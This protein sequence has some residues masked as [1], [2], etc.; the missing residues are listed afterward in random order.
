MRTVLNQILV[1]S[2]LPPARCGVATYAAEHI[3]Q[4]MGRAFVV[5]TA[6]TVSD[7]Q[8]EHVFEITGIRGCLSWLKFCRRQKGQQVC[9]HY[10]D[11]HFFPR[12]SGGWMKR[13]CC[14]LLQSIALR[15]LG[16]CSGNASVVFHELA[17]GTAM[18]VVSSKL[19]VF[20]FR[21]WK[22]L[23]FHT[24]SM[25][26]ECLR[27]YR[28]LPY[29]KCRIIEHA[30]QMCRKFDGTPSQAR[31]ILGLD[32]D[33]RIFLCIGFLTASKG[34]DAAIR[35]FH[36]SGIGA[37]GIA[38]LHI[39]GDTP[40]NAPTPSVLDIL[41]TQANTCP[42]VILHHGYVDDITFDIWL[43]ACDVLVL[44]YVGG[45]SSGVGARASLYG[46]RL[47]IRALPNLR[48]QFPFAD[49]FSS[50]DDLVA[51]LRSSNRLY[52]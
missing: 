22:E 41:R 49:V 19:R 46:K 29:E 43:A 20:A 21:G 32:R 38:Q 9:L 13:L 30:A 28:G 50:H 52:K 17:T 3:R 5:R 42:G 47:M 7:S 25:R 40:G 14:R 45:A 12:A 4:L 8:S 48:D 37:S 27:H 51:L 11:M 31:S 39:V 16:N 34:F 24:Q 10:T 36:E 44:P 6:T 23:Q 33:K 18:P 2:S 26:D 35:A 15:D 1:I